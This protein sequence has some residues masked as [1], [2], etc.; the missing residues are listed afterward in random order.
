M[1][2]LPRCPPLTQIATAAKEALEAVGLLFFEMRG[3]GR[4]VEEREADT[5]SVLFAGDKGDY[6][7]V[8]QRVLKVRNNTRGLSG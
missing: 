7:C 5:D 4:L 3:T 2:H 8:E 6:G 1:R